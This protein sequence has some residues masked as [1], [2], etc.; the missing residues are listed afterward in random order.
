MAIRRLCSVA[1][2]LVA[3]ALAVPAQG[4]AEAPDNLYLL[5]IP[6]LGEDTMDQPNRER[7]LV[8]L[9]TEGTRT[10]LRRVFP[11]VYFGEFTRWEDLWSR[12]LPEGLVVTREADAETVEVK[13][14]IVHMPVYYA[15]ALE[16]RETEP[17]HWEG[18]AKVEIFP[19]GHPMGG[20]LES[21]WSLQP[22]RSSDV[23][24]RMV[25][26]LEHL[27]K[28]SERRRPYYDGPPL[29]TAE[30]YVAYLR[31]GNWPLPEGSIFWKPIEPRF[32]EAIADALA[33]GRIVLGEEGF[34]PAEEVRRTFE[35]EG[36]LRGIDMEVTA[37]GI[38]Q[39]ERK[40]PTDQERRME[41][42][43]MEH[44]PPVTAY[45][46][47]QIAGYAD[48]EAAYYRFRQRAGY[49]DPEAYLGER[50]EQ[51]VSDSGYTWE[52]LAI[53]PGV[54]FLAEHISSVPGDLRDEVAERFITDGSE[55]FFPGMSWREIT[56][57]P[58][59]V[60]LV[61]C[62]PRMERTAKEQAE[63]LAALLR[64]E[65][66]TL[67]E[68]EAGRMSG[69]ARIRMGRKYPRW[70]YL[71][72]WRIRRD[73]AEKLAETPRVAKLLAA[74]GLEIEEIGQYPIPELVARVLSGMSADEAQALIDQTPKFKSYLRRTENPLLRQVITARQLNLE[75]NLAE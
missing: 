35:P 15:V 10:T 39:P 36:P 9:R 60:L 27:R 8:R 51:Y 61:A 28:L 46:I 65:G 5:H 7:H 62:L 22:A 16:G 6:G 11:E 72:R 13:G 43:L 45:R 57:V 30:G 38:P 14:I 54:A 66:H 41:R 44:R 20:H 74:S 17:G 71:S 23:Y 32:R 59:P 64:N 19:Y 73:Q 50:A 47:R 3:L 2:F 40:E 29:E 70:P 26:A 24:R 49:A 34:A 67:E 58:N 25:K 37:H 75:R 4:A 55:D 48:P 18:D 56:G 52:Q 42:L 53:I 69:T 31:E 68:L 63:E 1:I 33:K 12:Q 21:R